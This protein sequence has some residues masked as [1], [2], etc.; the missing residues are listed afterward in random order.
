MGTIDGWLD[1]ATGIDDLKAMLKPYDAAL[2]Q[3][4][5][6]SRAVNSVKNETEECI[7]AVKL[8]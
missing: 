2:M 7:K 8:R 5:A 1:P 4:Y 3:A 6:V